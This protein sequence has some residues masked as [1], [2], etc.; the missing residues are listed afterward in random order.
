MNINDSNIRPEL[1][2]RRLVFLHM[3]QLTN[4]PYIENDF[5]ALTDYELLCLVVKYLND[6]IANSNE[7]NTSI[8][9]L[10][11]A[12]LELQTYMNNSV[13]ELED[14]WNDKTNELEEA[15]NDRTTELENEWTDKTT[16]LETAFNNLQ[17]WIDN[18]F[19]NLDVQDEIDN[20]LDEMLQD[21][22]LEQII[23]QFLQSTAL[24]CFDTVQDM[25]N[26]TN[27][28]NGSYAKTLGYY[29]I[30][31]GGGCL[32]KI[33]NIQS[34]STYQE[35]LTSGLYATLIIKNNYLTPEMFGAKGDGSTD[36]TLA[37]T[38]MLSLNKNCFISPRTYKLTA[39]IVIP[40]HCSLQG[41]AHSRLLNSYASRKSILDF[42]GS[43]LSNVTLVSGNTTVGCE[44][45][46]LI[47]D[48]FQVSESRASQTI[49]NKTD[50]FTITVN[51]QNVNGFNV[52]YCKNC[53]AV[54]L[55]GSAF[56]VGYG[57]IEDCVAEFS[58]IAFKFNSDGQGNLL[59]SYYCNNCLRI[60]Y[61]NNITNV[62]GDSVYDSYCVIRGSGNILSNLTFDYVGEYVLDIDGSGNSISGIYGDRFG[63]NHIAYTSSDLENLVYGQYSPTWYMVSF[64]QKATEN[65]TSITNLGKTGG[66]C[67]SDNNLYGVNGLIKY[68][69]NVG[70]RNVE[71]INFGLIPKRFFYKRSFG[72]S[73][74]WYTDVAAFDLDDFKFLVSVD[75]Q[76]GYT[77]KNK[78]PMTFETEFG[79]VNALKMTLEFPS[80]NL[81]VRF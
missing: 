19:E 1:T 68:R 31:D 48:S 35:T 9:N 13:Q 23:E 42:R 74:T 32:Y 77:V 47:S 15:W 6:V 58:N 11:N 54:G 70:Q 53:S 22:V 79:I 56:E 62:R 76:G 36:D 33:T 40:D 44:N 16:E 20:K 75:D 46:C 14:A 49:A 50:W 3:Q 41:F 60:G 55:S 59:R 45:I 25:K 8:T 80:A 81:D 69:G 51:N 39:P 12:F 37:F 27:L 24:W 5:D 21:G 43:N 63:M 26:A 34:Q 30:N 71:A 18:Y 7:Q 4:F 78:C 57:I 61:N 2:F 38:N 17:T 28:V 72:T 65:S 66:L 64:N 67:K 52:N 10:Y 29:N 73:G